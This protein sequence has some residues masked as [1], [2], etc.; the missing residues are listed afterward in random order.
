MKYKA[1]EPLTTFAQAED[2]AGQLA[3]L[4][5][6]NQKMVYTGWMNGGLHGTAATR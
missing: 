2:I 3:D 1:V 5:V 4:G 6:K